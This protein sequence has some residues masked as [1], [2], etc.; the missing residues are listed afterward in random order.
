MSKVVKI[1]QSDVLRIAQNILEQE[2]FN[3]EPQDDSVELTLGQDENGV[4]YVMQ[5]ALNGEPI[6]VAKVK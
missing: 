4:F 5:N 6:I 2:N 1:K 3:K